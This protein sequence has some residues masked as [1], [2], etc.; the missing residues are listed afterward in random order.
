MAAASP[1]A[2]DDQRDIERLALRLVETPE[3]RRAREAARALL[4]ADPVARTPDGRLGLDRALD[5]WTLAL[6]MRVVNSDAHRPRIAWNV[7]NAPRTWFGH[8]YPGAAVAIDNPDN[9]NREIPI[10]GGSRYEVHGRYGAPPTQFT[11]EVVAEFDGYAGLGRT[12]CALTRQQIQADAEGRFVITIDAD[13][14]GGRPNH[15][16]CEGGVQWVF[17]RDSLSDWRQVAT[18]LE[19]RRVGGPAAAAG[20]TE[21]ELAQD[22]AA[23]VA[24]WV[25]FWRGFK[26][27]FLGYPEPNR[28]VGPIGREGGWGFLAGGRFEIA[29]DEAVVVRT[30]DGGAYYTGFQVADPWTI[31]PDP[32]HRT[33]SRNKAQA[34]R[35][36]DGGYTYVLA[37]SDPGVCNWIDTVGLHQ[38]W[39]LLRWQGVPAGL[40][41]KTLIRGVETIRLA[42]VDAVLADTPRADLAFRRTEVA[43]RV[44]THGLR[45]RHG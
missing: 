15:L 20:P 3:V 6:A 14:A 29:D 38:G 4:L 17:A 2:T 25:G 45:T 35:D 28:L 13:P 12:L 8:T 37:A 1:L 23:N 31:A 40:D 27:G 18:T 30:T 41:P 32:V 9:A 26:D 36:P 39:M 33:A 24:G 43:E 11:I 19:V 16:R 22:I 10:D 5:Q 34:L 44:H 21:A 7:Y 42:D